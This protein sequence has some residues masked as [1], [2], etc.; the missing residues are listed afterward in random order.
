MVRIVNA[1]LADGLGNLV[2]RCT[3][4]ALNVGQMRPMVTVESFQMCGAIG[5]ELVKLLEEIPKEVEA[6]YTN[7]EF[8]KSVTNTAACATSYS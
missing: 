4:K 6:F 5:T 7:W 2:S 8:Y 1:E 3:G